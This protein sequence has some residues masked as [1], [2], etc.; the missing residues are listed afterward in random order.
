M[1]FRSRDRLLD[2]REEEGVL[3]LRDLALEDAGA[4]LGPEHA[5]GLEACLRERAVADER[6]LLLQC[7]FRAPFRQM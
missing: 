7:Q 4:A 3:D 5:L 2:R 1:L 6:Q